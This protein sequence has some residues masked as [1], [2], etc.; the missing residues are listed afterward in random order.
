MTVQ[1]PSKP[2]PPPSPPPPAPERLTLAPDTA[3]VQVSR[4][5]VIDVLSNDIAGA[6]GGTLTISRLGTATGGTAR[7]VTVSGRQQVQFTARSAA[8]TGR[9]S[10]QARNSLRQVATGTVTVQIQSSAVRRPA[11]A[12]VVVGAAPAVMAGAA[13]AVVVSATPAVVAGAAPAVIAG[14]APA[15]DIAAAGR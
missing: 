5:V 14:A 8:G 1:L 15:A 6:R 12:A 11:P 3:V 2:P 4:S 9:L 13:P 7:I 10:Y